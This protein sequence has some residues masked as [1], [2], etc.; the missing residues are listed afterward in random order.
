MKASATFKKKAGGADGA[1]FFV[2]R[3]FLEW[4]FYMEEKSG[5]AGGASFLDTLFWG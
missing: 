3:L 1:P 2:M 5:D 4:L